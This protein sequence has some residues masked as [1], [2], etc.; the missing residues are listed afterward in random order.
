MGTWSSAGATLQNHVS[1]AIENQKQMPRDGAI[2]FS[3]LVGKL[4]VVNVA[5]SSCGRSG[6]YPLERVIN[7][8]GR[9]AKL[10]DWLD[11][12]T[13]DCPKKTGPEHVRS[14]RGAVSGFTEGAVRGSP[15]V[16][17]LM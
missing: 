13:A 14:M 10:I 4:D 15:C 9:A 8:R 5:R 6:H 17:A 2:I 11:E 7:A 1:F 12:I 16:I 3:D